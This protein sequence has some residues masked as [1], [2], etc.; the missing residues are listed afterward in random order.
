MKRLLPARY[1]VESLYRPRVGPSRIPTVC[2]LLVGTFQASLPDNPRRIGVGW[3][4]G[5]V[6]WIAKIWNRPSCRLSP[7]KFSDNPSESLGKDLQPRSWSLVQRTAT[8]LG[9]SAMVHP[10]ETR[11]RLTA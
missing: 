4:F 1:R 3:T 2:N 9:P 11:P 6:H 10:V 8:E 5:D 7:T